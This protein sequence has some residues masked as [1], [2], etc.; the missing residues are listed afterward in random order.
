MLLA[1]WTASIPAELQEDLS[2]LGTQM[3]DF[4]IQSPYIAIKKLIK[5]QFNSDSIS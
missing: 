3:N 4:V 2:D 5:S 1:L